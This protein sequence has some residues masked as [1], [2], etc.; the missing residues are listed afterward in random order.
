MNRL[1]IRRPRRALILAGLGLATAIPAAALLATS[2][3]PGEPAQAALTPEAPATL[4]VRTLQVEPAAGYSRRRVYTGRVEPFRHADLGFE[5]AGLLRQVLV[6]EGDPVRAGD[7][8]ARLDSALLEARRAELAA[9]LRTA[10]ADRALAQATLERYQGSVDQGAVT[11]Q[12]LDEARE[13]ARSAAAGLALARSRIASVDLDIAKSALR[14]PFDGTV[15]RR[16]ADEGRVLGA[17]EPV[18]RVQEAAVPEIRIGVAS[19]LA[20]TLHPGAEYRLAWRG[21]DLPARL[22]AVLPLRNGAARTVDALFVP[23]DPEALS[24]T[25]LRA[26]ELVEVELS[27]WVEEPGAWLPLTALTEGGRG[28]WSAYAVEP[29][30]RGTG[31]AEGRETGEGLAGG[32]L[33]VRPLEVL[34]QDGDRV[35]VRGA[36][37]AGETLVATGLHR[38]VPGQ[39]VRVL[40]A[41][42]AQVAERARRP[43]DAEGR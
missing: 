3:N 13:G 8:L 16:R 20:D 24:T 40:G 5:R 15:T 18:L 28:L 42:E 37:A 10:E 12:A 41:G 26:G 9:A 1:R 2:R 30:A 35:F 17:G 23:H 29:A 25:A 38:V 4:G 31:A 36:L 6:R 7:V 34:Y 14:A 11:R 22:R 27:Q 39:L 43:L 19:P 33:A 21:R 32:R